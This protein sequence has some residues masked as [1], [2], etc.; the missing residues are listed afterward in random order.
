MSQAVLLLAYLARPALAHD[1]WIEPDN[2]SPPVGKAV[3]VRVFVGDH[4][5]REAERPFQKKLTVS[6]RLVSAV[7]TVDL[8]TLGQE[9]KIPLTE[10]LCPDQGS[11]WVALE[12]APVGITL[13]ADKFNRYLE[14]ERLTA[15]REERKR[16]KEDGRP[17][18]ER[19]S[20][21]LKCLLRAGGTGDAT[22][23]KVLGH[24]LEIVLLAD[25]H[26]ATGGMLKVRLLFEGKPLPNVALFALCKEGKQVTEQ[27]LATAAD[28]TAE[29]KLLGKGIWLLRLVHMRRCA[30]RADADWE[31]FW[32]SLTFELR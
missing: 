16:A 21:Y 4:F 28:G 17:G 20:R 31:S 8:R 29:V 6:L 9:G 3:A 2:F 5:N 12:R 11:Y 15:I 25:P 24:R 30:G 23:E 1:Y 19:Y 32:T 22:W 27:K 14:D 10:V 26:A 7:K 13:A 18:R